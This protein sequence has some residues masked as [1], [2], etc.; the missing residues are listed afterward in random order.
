MAR[1]A[2]TA[3]R[4]APHPL[5]FTFSAGT[6]LQRHSSSP[7]PPTTSSAL[8][9]SL[10]SA[11]P[12]PP[13]LQ[14]PVSSTHSIISAIVG[15]TVV[16]SGWDAVTWATTNDQFPYLKGLAGIVSEATRL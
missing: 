6:W 2:C 13:C 15:M 9:V 16:A 4:R 7:A 12:A 11:M 3:L 8:S 10:R 1:V 14:L 5:V